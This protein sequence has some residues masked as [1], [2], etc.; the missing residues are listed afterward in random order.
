MNTLQR[1]IIHFVLVTNWRSCL[2]QAYIS[3][4]ITKTKTEI[5]LNLKKNIYIY[6]YNTK[7]KKN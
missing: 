5:K 2:S 6:I 1:N 7:Y 3:T 4:R